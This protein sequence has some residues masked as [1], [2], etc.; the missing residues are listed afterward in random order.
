MLASVMK[1]GPQSRP[2]RAFTLIEL[3]VVIAIIAILAALLLPA[4]SKAKA[5]A[6]EIKCV[7]NLRQLT[8]GLLM[9]AS[10]HDDEIPYMI[11]YAP[12]RDTKSWRSLL[13]PVY[14][15][16]LNPELAF[17]RRQGPSKSIWYCPTRVADLWR[18]D[19]TPRERFT[20]R[21]GAV[22]NRSFLEG[23]Q[24]PNK[25]SS[26]LLRF[27]QLPVQAKVKTSHIRMPAT[28]MVFLDAGA[29]VDSPIE[30]RF[31]IPDN[32]ADGVADLPSEV[33][34]GD[35]D[36]RVHR[37]G[38]QMSLLDGHVERVH[39]RKLWHLDEKGQLTHPYWYPE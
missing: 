28:A 3:L 9:Y 25:L 37:D 38:S 29:E 35:N 10:D 4:L 33:K 20:S 8:L 26:L 11:A 1:F 18:N 16:G 30:S 32:D 17:R 7:S 34:P 15:P 21:I 14:V 39:Y 27:H 23:D 22:S 6:K 24:Y 13:W 5:M 12:S 2:I 19:A 36:F 31:V